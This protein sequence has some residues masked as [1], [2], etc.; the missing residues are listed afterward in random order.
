ME[1]LKPKRVYLVG[2]PASGKSRTGKFLAEVLGVPHWDTDKMVENLAGQ[3]IPTIFK[4]RGQAKF[5][6]LELE[7]VRLSLRKE[8]VFSLGGGAIE[9]PEI[10]KILAGESVVWIHAEKAELLRRVTRNITKRP[11]LQDDPEGTLDEMIARRMSLFA[12]VYDLQVNST[13]SHHIAVVNQILQHWWGLHVVPVAV[14]NPYYVLVGDGASELAVNYLPKGTRKCMIVSP[15]A[16]RVQA[17]KLGMKLRHQG[18]EDHH[19]VHENGEVA[20]SYQSAIAGWNALAQARIGRG[21]LIITVGGGVTSDLGG[22]L[23]ATWMRG[24]QVVHVSTT[25]L[26]M[27]DA[28]IGGKTGI[29]TPYGKNLVGAFHDPTVVFADTSML[30]TLPT[31]EFVS[32]LAELIKCGFIADTKILE[33]IQADINVLNPQRS[34]TDPQLYACLI[35]LIA[36]AIKVKAEVVSDD[37]FESGRREILNYGHTAGHALELASRYTKRHGE[38]VAVGCIFAA[39]VA[40]KLGYLTAAEVDRHVQLFQAAGL[41]TQQ[42]DVS[43]SF[44]LEAMR[45]DKKVRGDKLRFVLLRGIGNPVVESVDDEVL[46]VGARAIGA[47]LDS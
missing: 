18:V 29:D 3:D 10:R 6:E 26:G 22:F 40:Q 36:R 42:E 31:E 4:T 17:Q 13:A 30:G 45:G 19:F 1:Y 34:L 11:L 16:M 47:D 7:A 5:R 35:D 14:E 25:L 12:E 20:K 21:D 41:P 43:W 23:A 38:A 39:T 2:L 28:A 33:L 32:G 46:K 27:V 44:M 9:T 24:V 37:K 15:E 8:G